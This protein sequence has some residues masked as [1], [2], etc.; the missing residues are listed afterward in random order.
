M[1]SGD[2]LGFSGHAWS[3]AGSIKLATYGCPFWSLSH[4]G[5]VGAHEGKLLVFESDESPILP[6]A[7]RKVNKPAKFRRRGSTKIETYQ[8]KVWHYPLAAGSIPSRR[9]ASISFCTEHRHRLRRHRCL[10]CRRLGFS[11]IESW[12]REEN[13]SSLFCSEYCCRRPP[14][15]RLVPTTTSDAGVRIASSAKNVGWAVA[16]A[17]ETQMKKLFALI[18]I[19]AAAG[20]QVE[21]DEQSNALALPPDEA[22]IRREYPTVNLPHGLRQKNWVGDRGEGSVRS[23]QHDMLFRWQGFPAMADWWR[24]NNAN[25]EWAEDLALKSSTTPRCDS[26]RR[27]RRT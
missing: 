25:G 12:L 8:G 7:I 4:V 10:A 24:Q 6:C 14:R 15:D 26:H 1:H 9:T 20:C 18:L 27:P 5:I 21:Q 23:C 22:P 19:V 2:L 11:W 17:S 3:G 13:L 16:Q